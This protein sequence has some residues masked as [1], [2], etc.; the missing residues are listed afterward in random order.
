[1]TRCKEI[2]RMGPIWSY[3]ENGIGGLVM[4][5]QL[6]HTKARALVLSVMRDMTTQTVKRTPSA[7]LEEGDGI[8]D[9]M[10]DWKKEMEFQKVE[11]EKKHI[12]EEEKKIVN[13]YL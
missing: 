6:Q 4:H 3:D 11:P 7:R 12:Y 8:S 1:M 13:M 10:Q 5:K 2:Y 9:Q